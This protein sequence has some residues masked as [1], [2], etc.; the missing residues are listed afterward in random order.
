MGVD[1]TDISNAAHLAY[2]PRKAGCCAPT[3]TPG[4]PAASHAVIGCI[5]PPPTPQEALLTQG[6]A[7]DP[8]AC[9]RSHSLRPYLQTKAHPGHS[10]DLLQ[11]HCARAAGS[12]C[13]SATVSLGDPE[14]FRL[15]SSRVPISV[16]LD[17]PRAPP[18]SSS[19]MT[20]QWPGTL[21]APK[22]SRCQGGL[23]PD[24]CLY[25]PL[26]SGVTV[27]GTWSPGVTSI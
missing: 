24:L 2:A 19:F 17:N 10:W 1:S 18:A 5:S 15:S 7:Q 26:G 14:T 25:L 11:H 20:R 12:S 16:M 21:L 6:S 3:P 13:L 4:R 27:A 9:A 8:P 23:Y 22:Q